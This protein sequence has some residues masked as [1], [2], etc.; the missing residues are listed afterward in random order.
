MII[1]CVAIGILFFLVTLLIRAEF[2]E[3][4]TQIYIFKPLS[5]LTVIFIAL[6]P[7]FSQN[8]VSPI[9]FYFILAGL[10]FS[11]GGDVALISKSK[12]AFML[13]LVFFLVT[14][15]IY[16]I[17]FSIPYQLIR[18]DLI[19]GVILSTIAAIVYAYLFK[20]LGGLKL[21]VLFYVI[22]I[23]VMLNRAFASLYNEY[24]SFTRAVFITGGAV[25][26]YLSDLILAINKF[27]HPFKLNRISLAFYYSGQLLI[28]LSIGK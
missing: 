4:L 12:K 10:L 8:L 25:L 19:P 28:A 17:A 15:I 22:I 21:P 18:H 2:A 20:G 7:V 24:F 27:R 11:F 9:Y 16:T 23:T 26:F 3:N 6:I 13:G 1:Y 5:T 14:H